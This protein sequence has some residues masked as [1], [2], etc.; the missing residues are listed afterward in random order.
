[1]IPDHL[2]VLVATLGGQPQVVTFTLDLLLAR[3]YPISEVFVVHPRAAAPSRLYRSLLRLSGEFSGQRYPGARNPLHFHSCLLELDGAPIDDICD[4]AHADGTLDTLHRLISD[5]KRDGYRIHL[6]VSGG[7]RLMALLALSVA[8][9]NFDRHDHI[10]HIYTPQALQEQ[11][12]EGAIMHA[13]P[14]SGVTLLQGP[15]ITLGAYIHDPRQSFRSA[16]EEQQFQMEAQERARCAEV[17]KK[18]SPAQLKVLQAFSKGLKTQ[19][20][21]SELHITPATVHTHKTVLL[22]LCRTIWNIPE[23]EHIDYHFL[24]VKFA[25]Y[26]VHV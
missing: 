1:M 14:D 18:A 6:S 4:D 24:H 2:H 25:S 23:H 20:V 13:P 21:A 9:F 16:Q 3:G 15:F 26:F 10:W 19:Q 22:D 8:V 12:H 7:R 17:V 5:L 11:A